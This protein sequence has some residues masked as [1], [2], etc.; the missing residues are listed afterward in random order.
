MEERLQAILERIEISSL[1]EEDKIKMYGIISEGLKASIWPAL[2]SNMPKEKLESFLKQPAK[3][4]VESY[5]S[6]IEDATKSGKALDE[7]EETMNTLLDEIES[8]LTEEKI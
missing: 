8:V 7:V 2:M 4:T 1:S 5:I 6:L 3:A